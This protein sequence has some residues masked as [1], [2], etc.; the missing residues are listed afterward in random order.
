MIT[1][2]KIITLII[3]SSI[4]LAGCSSFYKNNKGYS[5]S[6]NKTKDLEVSEHL[7]VNDPTSCIVNCD[8]SYSQDEA[9]LI[10]VH[11]YSYSVKIHKNNLATIVLHGDSSA[12]NLSNHADR[13]YEFKS[14]INAEFSAKISLIENNRIVFTDTS[15]V[16]FNMPQLF[17][18]Y[19]LDIQ[20][21]V[22]ELL[23]SKIKYDIESH[24]MWF[25]KSNQDSNY[26]LD[27]KNNLL[28]MKI[29]D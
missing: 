7:V 21:K 13:N 26:Y 3:I 19:F 9:F 6:L 28:I 25:K 2:S 16:K 18:A 1:K 29:L 22:G 11:D 5:E 23:K 8:S 24:R 17:P 4:A 10:K 14:K 12:E 27:S 20:D 15:L